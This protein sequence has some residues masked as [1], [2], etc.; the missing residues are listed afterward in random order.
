M[1]VF[2]LE[3]FLGFYQIFKKKLYVKVYSLNIYYHRVFRFFQ[4][5]CLL[6]KTDKYPKAFDFH[7]E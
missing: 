4:F 2:F 1:K 6:I 7:K 5:F 3:H